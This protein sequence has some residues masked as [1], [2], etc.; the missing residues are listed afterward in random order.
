[1]LTGLRGMHKRK[2]KVNLNGTARCLGMDGADS[3]EILHDRV[4]GAADTSYEGQLTRT[5]K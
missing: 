2:G 1:M 4:A 5:Q 3:K